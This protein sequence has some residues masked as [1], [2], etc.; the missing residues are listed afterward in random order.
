MKSYQGECGERDHRKRLDSWY[1][2]NFKCKMRDDLSP[3]YACEC[4]WDARPPSSVASPVESFRCL[5]RDT[6]SSYEPFR[7]RRR[8]PRPAGAEK[9]LQIVCCQ[10]PNT[11]RGDRKR[12]NIRYTLIFR[13]TRHYFHYQYYSFDQFIIESIFKRS[14]Q[15]LS[16]RSFARRLSESIM[17]FSRLIEK[18]LWAASVVAWHDP[19]V[20]STGGDC[21][22]TS[23]EL[24][25]KPKL[26]PAWSAIISSSR[27]T[28][29]VVDTNCIL[30]YMRIFK[31]KYF[32]SNIFW[33][34]SWQ[35]LPPLV[36]R[37]YLYEGGLVIPLLFLLLLPSA[38]KRTSHMHLSVGNR[39]RCCF[40][41]SANRKQGTAAELGDRG[42]RSSVARVTPD[43]GHCQRFLYVKV[44][45]WLRHNIPLRTEDCDRDYSKKKTT[46]NIFSAF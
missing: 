23:E 1:Y 7:Q 5:A 29:L 41:S 11:R 8:D 2:F 30:F 10:T 43:A 17:N 9:H 31:K 3:S 24:F 38:G 28:P 37:L 15:L 42:P 21:L 12:W 16:L 13:S 22:L 20:V 32:E 36:F 25:V 33:E 34:Y 19:V 44:W 27:M 4:L 40:M 18:A 45:S 6:T 14:N 35:T 39:C 26:L 46:T